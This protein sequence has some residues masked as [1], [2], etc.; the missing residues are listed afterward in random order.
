MATSEI[1]PRVSSEEIEAR[2]SLPEPTERVA[3]QVQGLY[4]ICTEGVM[5]PLSREESVHSGPVTL[6]LDPQSPPS[7]NFGIVDYERLKLRVRYGVQVVFPALY[8]L[9][10][11][12][13]HDRA[14]LAPIRAV[15]TDT[16]EVSPDLSGWRALGR[17][18]F[19]PGSLWS[20]AG[21]G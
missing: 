12:G 6:T 16:C 20:G 19:L 15:A 10:T 8:D 3:F 18:D 5:L 1:E 11:R 4:G 2:R 7:S 13:Q 9:V 21:G 17:M 14:L